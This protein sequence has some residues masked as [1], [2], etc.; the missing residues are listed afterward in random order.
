MERQ[1]RVL[2]ALRHQLD[3]LALLLRFSEFV[4]IAQDSLFTTLSR[5]DITDLAR[6]AEHVD[7]SKVQTHFFFPPTFPEYVNDDALARIRAEVR[8]VFDTPV[9]D[10]A[11][12]PT[13]L[14]TATPRLEA[15]PAS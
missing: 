9:V 11:A 14:P 10:P 15:C 6:L 5:E 12:S 1:Q 8:G 13:P 2:V 4:D 3:P 7:A